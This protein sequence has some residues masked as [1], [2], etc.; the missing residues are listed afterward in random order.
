MIIES[1]MGV[2]VSVL[3]FDKDR[4]W[5]H[6]VPEGWGGGGWSSVSVSGM[7]IGFNGQ[8]HRVG[9]SVSVLGVVK[10]RG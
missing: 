6:R 1:Q 8:G 4:V 2:P 7:F 9:C 10:D 3:G 5:I